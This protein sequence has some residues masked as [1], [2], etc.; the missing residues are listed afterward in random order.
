MGGLRTR[1]TKAHSGAT[2]TEIAD[3]DRVRARALLLLL[4]QSLSVVGYGLSAKKLKIFESHGNTSYLV[5]FNYFYFRN[6]K[7]FRIKRPSRPKFLKI[8]KIRYQ[9]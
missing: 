5:Y 7:D 8:A 1:R 9:R 4:P 2:R 3:G 6:Y